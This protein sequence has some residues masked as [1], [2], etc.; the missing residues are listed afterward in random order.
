MA[1]SGV[2][3][4]SMGG[5]NATTVDKLTFSN[6]TSSALSTGLSVNMNRGAGYAHCEALAQ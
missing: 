1:D 6:D 3:G 4:Y 5:S 2:A